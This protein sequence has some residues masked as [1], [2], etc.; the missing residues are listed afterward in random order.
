MTRYDFNRMT[1]GVPEM[2]QGNKQE[3]G[4]LR[5]RILL[6]TVSLSWLLIIITLGLYVAANIPFQKKTLMENME[7]EA[8]NL[9]APIDQVTTAAIITGD[10][11]AAGEHCTGVVRDGSAIRYLVITWDNGSSLVTTSKGWKQTQLD[12]IWNPSD[13]RTAKGEIIKSGLVG[14]EV[15]HFSYPFRH[16]GR[17]RGWIHIG[18]SLN[19]YY[20]DLNN[21][22]ARTS[23]LALLCIIAA[24][25]ISF[26]FTRKLVTPINEL[27]KMAQRVAAGDLSARVEIRTGDELERLGHS[28]NK[29]ARRLEQSRSELISSREYTDNIIK[30]MNDALIVTDTS[31]KIMT[32]NV[33][34]L[35]MLG[36]S[37][38][39]LIGQSIGKLMPDPIEQNSRHNWKSII[40]DLIE[41]GYLSNTEITFIS[42]DGILIPVLFSGSVM[43]NAEG[44]VEGIVCVALDITERKENE[45]ALKEAKEAAV[46]ASLA[47]S[48]FLANMSHEIR[49]PVNGVLGMLELLQETKLTAE[50]KRLS[51]IALSSGEALLSV[52]NNILDLSKIEAGRVELSVD[53][54]DLYKTMEDSVQLMAD[55]SR[56][57]GLK[58]S[59]RISR[60]VPEFVSGDPDRLRQ[61]LINLIG[62]A[63]KF[64]EKGEVSLD[65]NLISDN[66]DDVDI[67]F[68]VRDTGIGIKPELH[69][70]L[71]MPFCQADASTTRKYGGTGLGLAISKQLAELMKG[72]LTFES[73]QGKGST[74]SLTA[75]F[76]K[77]VAGSSKSKSTWDGLEGV[78][79]LVVDDVNTHRGFVTDQL[80]LW[81]IENRSADSADEALHIIRTARGAGRPYDFAIIGLDALKNDRIELIR[82]MNEDPEIGGIRIITLSSEKFDQDIFPLNESEIETHLTKPIVRSRLFNSMV[83]C[84]KQKPE[85]VSKSDTYIPGA[86]SEERRRGHVLLAEDNPVNQLVAQGMLDSLGF[87]VEI[88]NNGKDAVEAFSKNDYDLVFM[89]CQ[90]PE[91]DG[92]EA[93]KAIRAVE[94]QRRY[95]DAGKRHVPIIALT[96]HAMQGDRDVCL[97]AGM[98]DYLVKPFKKDQLFEVIRRWR[99][100]ATDKSDDDSG[101]HK[102]QGS[103]N[104]AAKQFDGIQ[105]D[106]MTSVIDTAV[107]DTIMSSKK[108]AGATLVTRVI[109]SFIKN[110]QMRLKSLRD[111]VE[112]GDARETGFLAH[113]LKSSSA[114]VGALSLA[115]LFEKMD[116]LSRGREM[117]KV[118]TIFREVEAASE[119]VFTALESEIQSRSL[120]QT[121]EEA[122]AD[123]AQEL[124]S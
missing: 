56:L 55:N 98:D 117:D 15:F 44:N 65:V 97:A 2:E 114:T 23:W 20:S 26:F 41:K 24:M 116:S 28:F 109:E 90:M 72:S 99:Q 106:F 110:T 70:K 111:A 33:A 76:G 17:D 80:T 53:R 64:T 100:T 25:A 36:Y 121:K 48:Q 68:S 69:E 96:A 11:G 49:T 61:I 71:L 39:E 46:K 9:V 67:L 21:L 54:F 102:S 113:T 93:S 112:R 13:S 3:A 43:H 35:V 4:F 66:P 8:K 95:G 75:R 123:A 34:A 6:R 47:K 63:V 124:K 27:D 37:E 118:A 87:F 18:L 57:K 51:D 12:G 86:T 32:V 79:V 5:Q 91:M 31:G 92:Y 59:Y 122:L 115:R 85:S 14:E 1:A 74:F 52:I 82:K 81:G 84:I 10:F 83:S 105:P 101:S 29:M 73:A 77:T 89:D 50:Q 42:K 60:E 62:N 120:P 78:R 22:Y 88:A 30:S 16:S 107:L 94:R 58:L 104:T 38:D 103:K 108:N 40:R 19:K 119:A 7:S 45:D